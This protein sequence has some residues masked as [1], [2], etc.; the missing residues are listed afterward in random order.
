MNYEPPKIIDTLVLELEHEILGASSEVIEEEFEVS[1]TGQ[2]V[3]EIQWEDFTST[4]E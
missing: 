4:W 1:T 3:Y 2:E